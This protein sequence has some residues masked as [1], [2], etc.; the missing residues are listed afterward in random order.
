MP[1]MKEGGQVERKWKKFAALVLETG[2]PQAAALEVFN[3]KNK[4]SAKAMGYNMM[5]KPEI[6]KY[7]N[8]A[9]GVQDITP[10]YVLGRIKKVADY[11]KSE[12]TR[13]RALE[14]L[15]KYLKM[16]SEDTKKSVN[17]NVD[18]TY[19][20]ANK[21]LRSETLLAGKESSRVDVVCDNDDA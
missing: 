9:L 11:S 5:Q 18:L 2:S 10:E 15:G 13:L 16:F 21:I 4:D 12:N 1:R 7:I 8:N 19:E 20:Q 6:K 3:C 14:L 17:L